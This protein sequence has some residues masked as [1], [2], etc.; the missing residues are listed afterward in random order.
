MEKQSKS[1]S[2]SDSPQ[3]I[4]RKLDQKVQFVE[5]SELNLHSNKVYGKPPEAPRYNR[6]GGSSNRL[7]NS[8]SNNSI[9]SNNR[10]QGSNST[11]NISSNNSS[12]ITVIIIFITTWLLLFPC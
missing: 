1:P 7:Q 6:F 11:I 10:L 4:G 3:K 2:R 12:S 9:N 5:T 8:S